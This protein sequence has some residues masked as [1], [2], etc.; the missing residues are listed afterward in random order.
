M[1]W[2]A[3]CCGTAICNTLRSPKF[4]FAAL[5]TGCLPD[6]GALGPV[7]ASAFV[8]Q[9][10]GKLAHQNRLRLVGGTLWRALSARLSGRWR[11]T[12]FFDTKTGTPAAPVTVLPKETRQQLLQP[13]QKMIAPRPARF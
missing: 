12:P 5:H 2:Q 13:P 3:T 7:T 9:P 8:P 4:A 6:A 11:H 10:N 1:R